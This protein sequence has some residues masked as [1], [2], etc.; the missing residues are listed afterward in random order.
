LCGILALRVKV[1]EKRCLTSEEATL[2]A[3][4]NRSAD[5]D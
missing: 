1:E 5:D 3:A 2:G 4:I